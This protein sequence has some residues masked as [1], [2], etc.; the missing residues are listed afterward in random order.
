MYLQKLLM[1]RDEH[2]TKGIF[3]QLV[4]KDH[5][6]NDKRDP[7]KVQIAHR[8]PYHKKHHNA[9]LENSRRSSH[10]KRAQ[11]TTTK[12]TLQN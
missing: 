3:Q 12:G 10:R 9:E 4:T 2:W 5:E 6:K 11:R 8:P 1:R 7:R